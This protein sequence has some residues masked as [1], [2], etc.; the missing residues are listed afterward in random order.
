[1]GNKIA[2]VTNVL[3]YVGPPAVKALLEN[4]YDVVAHDPAFQDANQQEDYKSDNP[5]TIPLGIG[6]PDKLIQHLWDNYGKVDVI[7][8]NDTFPA[9]HVPID[10]ANVADLNATIEHVLVYPFKLMQAAIPRLKKQGRGNVI[11]ITSC[12]TEL[13]LPGG[14]I[15]DIARAGANALVKSL[16]LDLAPYGIPVNAIAPNYL[17]SEAYFPKAK[18]IDNPVGRDFI[19]EVVPAGRLGEPEEIG[20]LI[21]YLANMKGSFHTGTI[22]KFAGGWPAAPKRP[23]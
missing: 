6:E 21:N 4:G 11:M 15:P 5:G 12:R 13:P 8:S 14:A 1:M 3:D 9:I 16:S 17:Y 19:S 10:E 18:F 23:I 22:I 7:V 2:L 20:E